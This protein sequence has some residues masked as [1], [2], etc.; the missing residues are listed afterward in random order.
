MC[1][2]PDT[3]FLWQL[4]DHNVQAY[5]V[6]QVAVPPKAPSNHPNQVLGSVF[7]L[8]FYLHASTQDQLSFSIPCHCF[9]LLC[10]SC[11]VSASG[12]DAWWGYCAPQKTYTC[13]LSR[14][15]RTAKTELEVNFS[16]YLF[17]KSLKFTDGRTQRLVT[18]WLRRKRPKSS[19]WLKSFGYWS[20]LN[21]SLPGTGL[22]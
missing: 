16:F 1:G 22:R 8:S 11:S 14:K 10:F 2:S 12:G 18:S 4:E 17:V 7:S 21:F 9:P 19:P 5:W 6:L 3:S 15:R 13:I 20:N